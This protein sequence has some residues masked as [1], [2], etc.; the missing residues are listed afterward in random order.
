MDAFDNGIVNSSNFP[1]VKNIIDRRGKISNKPRQREA[2]NSSNNPCANYSVKQLKRDISKLTK[3]KKA[4]VNETEIKENRLLSL[5]E[6]LHAI[7][8][9]DNAVELIEAENI[10]SIPALKGTYN[11]T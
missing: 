6:G 3:E 1:T 5:I 10:G 7:W 8:N 11:V 4:F 2:G 9:D